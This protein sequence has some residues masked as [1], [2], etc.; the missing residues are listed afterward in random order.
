M[1][2]ET[3]QIAVL[4]S[5]RKGFPGE[6]VNSARKDMAQA[7]CKAGFEPLMLDEQKTPYGAVSNAQEAAQF[8]LMVKQYHPVG[9]IVC[10]PNFGDESSAAL[11]CRDVHV[12][13]LIQA[14]PDTEGLMDPLHRRDAFCG[15]ISIQNVFRQYQIPTRCSHL[16]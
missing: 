6:L 2:K 3:D 9:V 13:I 16:M 11:A 4:F 8:D 10:L 7:L 15:K 12:P 5:S 14:Y 1:K